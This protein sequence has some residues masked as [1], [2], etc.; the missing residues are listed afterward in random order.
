MIKL[1][2]LAALDQRI[3]MRY[4]MDA[5]TGEETGSYIQHHVKLA[6]LTELPVRGSQIDGQPMIGP[7]TFPGHGGR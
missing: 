4:V 6:L 2:V 5:M 3:A 7:V 1:G